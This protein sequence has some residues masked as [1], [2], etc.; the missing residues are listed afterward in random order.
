MIELPSFVLLDE[1]N[2]NMSTQ[3]HLQF[4]LN[5]YLFLIIRID[6]DKVL[7]ITVSMR[8]IYTHICV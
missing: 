3:M 7:R 8:I 5:D 2:I 4:I 1:S 6:L